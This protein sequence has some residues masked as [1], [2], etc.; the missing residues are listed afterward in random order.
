MQSI[1]CVVYTVTYLHFTGPPHTNIR[2]NEFTPCIIPPS[3]MPLPMIDSMN[4]DQ[5][6][7][8]L[9]ELNQQKLQ[10]CKYDNCICEYNG[11]NFDG[12]KLYSFVS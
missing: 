10:V 7:A 6:G 2:H 5:L 12:Q 1:L 9:V 8:R 3:D 11:N 4:C